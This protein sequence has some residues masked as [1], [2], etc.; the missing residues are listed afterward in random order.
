MT[1]SPMVVQTRRFHRYKPQWFLPE[2]LNCSISD[3][4]RDKIQRRHQH[5]N[6]Q[7]ELRISSVPS[8]WS[9]AMS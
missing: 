2:I 8:K 9:L 7:L 3:D 6:V 1:V 5:V 4:W